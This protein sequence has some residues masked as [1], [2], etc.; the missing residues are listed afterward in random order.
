M[1]SDARSLNQFYTLPLHDALP[2]YT[3]S[4]E[5]NWDQIS[6]L[7]GD[8]D[9]DVSLEQLMRDYFLPGGRYW[10]ESFSDEQPGR[11]EEHTSE[12]Q[13]PCNIVLRLLLVNIKTRNFLYL[14]Y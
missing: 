13:S 9:S 11:S 3:S 12:L 7:Y 2:I 4:I 8:G 10:G 1:M 5:D 14:Q 6:T